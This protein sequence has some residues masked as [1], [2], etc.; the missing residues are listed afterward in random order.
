MIYLCN[1]LE[2][3]VR[4]MRRLAGSALAGAAALLAF[5]GGASAASAAKLPNLPINDLRQV[6]ADGVH[7]HVYLASSGGLV[8]TNLA[9][10]LV[11]TVVGEAV[12]H[13]ALS[14]DGNTLYAVVPGAHEVAAFNTKTLGAT[15]PYVLPT[16]DAPVGLA[17]QAGKIWVSYSSAALTGAIG[18][19]KVGSPTFTPNA[20][21]TTG[22]WPTAPLLAADP[23][24]VTQG[25]LVAIDNEADPTMIAT[26]NVAGATP[27]TPL[28]ENDAFVACT[29]LSDLAV[30]A[31]GAQ[32]L[33]ACTGSATEL[34]FLANLTPVVADYASG[35]STDAVAIAPDNSGIAT[36]TD[37]ATAPQLA[38]FKATGTAVNAYPLAAA[39]Y[40]V[41]PD[42]LSWTSD[43][44]KLIAVLKTG[45]GYYLDVL[46]YP[47]YKTSTLDLTNSGTFSAGAKVTLHGKLELGGTPAPAGVTVKVFRQVVG[48][49]ALTTLTTH[50]VAG[51]TYTLTD[52]PPHYGHYY[53]TAYYATTG[54]Y[55]PNWHSTLVIV[56]ALHTTLR[57]T[58]PTS[59][60]SG[61]TVQVTARLGATYSSRVVS[62]YAQ[63]AG[64]AKK[65]VKSG[66]VNAQGVL[67]ISY[68]VTK[69]TTFTAVFAGD[70]HYAAATA[71]ATVKG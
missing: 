13:M 63:P 27:A 24:P 26:Y 9:G 1:T 36:G 34:A 58:A 12:G 49:S 61:T 2:K 59:V 71:T 54:T 31:G 40:V 53:Y 20:L 29:G 28:A 22:V 14:P 42:G 46:E 3:P 35:A 56:N 60:T 41:A 57:L 69:N 11:K 66:K 10:N 70:A 67:T 51:G 25:T 68:K 43:A 44:T 64:G 62:I 32:F 47:Q 16:G 7:D 5:S 21:N 45:N 48:S 37:G 4:Y 52:T 33:L 50:T 8:V 55:A 18:Y 38:T 17:F 39:G 19:F 65:L 30:T 15:A 23:N 6:I